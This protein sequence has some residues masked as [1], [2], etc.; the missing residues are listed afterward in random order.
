MRVSGFFTSAVSNFILE[1]I[2]CFIMLLYVFLL[3]YLLRSGLSNS[4]T[5]V[6]HQFVADAF[7]NI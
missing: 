6:F 4:L 1:T 5:F 2:T 3:V 7:G